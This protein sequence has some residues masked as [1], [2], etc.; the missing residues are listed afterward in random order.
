MVFTRANA[1]K[2]YHRRS[3]TNYQTVRL[4]KQIVKKEI[5][6]AIEDK[7]RVISLP[8]STWG[9]VSTSWAEGALE[10]IAQG[11]NQGQRIGNKIQIK[12]FEINGVLTGGQTVPHTNL[13]DEINRVRMV[14]G[15]YNGY[16]NV[17]PMTTSGITSNTPVDHTTCRGLGYRFYDKWHVL[18]SDNDLS[19]GWQVTSKPFRYVKRFKRP[20]T[21]NYSDTG[22]NTANKALVISMISDSTAV[23]N[24]GF[25]H[26]YLKVI[27]QDA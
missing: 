8:A 11:T 20:L 22:A 19:V 7:F 2:R 27:Y 15:V 1:F 4:V 12:S 25:T 26:G 10:Q 13:D 18:T 16:Q 14:M 17:T 3:K 9:S 6:S 5:D 24:V 21:I 23:P